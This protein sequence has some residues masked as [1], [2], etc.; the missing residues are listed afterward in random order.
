MEELHEEEGEEDE[1]VEEE[2]KIEEEE[3][4]ET[5]VFELPH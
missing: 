4:Q 1:K 3:G 5:D 2:V